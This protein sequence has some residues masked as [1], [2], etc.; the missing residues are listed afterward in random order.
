M[1]IVLVV[2]LMGW[3]MAF[4]FTLLNLSRVERLSVR[5]PRELPLVSIIIP[6]R[7]EEREIERTLSAL[8]SQTYPAIEIIVIDDRSTDS[9]PLILARAAAEDPRITVIS[10]V[11]EPP[12]G[13]LGKPWALHRGSLA[14][15]GELL[16]FVDAD[17]HY[18]PDAVAA[19]V[20]E[21]EERDAALLTLLPTVE[22][23]GFWEHVLMPNLAFFIYTV[24]PLWRTNRS[25]S[26]RLAVGGGTGNLVR[27]A[28]Y[29]AVG[30][31][32]TLKDAVVDDVAL[33][34]LMRKR[35]RR[36]RVVRAEDFVSVRMYHGLGEILGG[37]TKNAFAVFGRS[38]VVLT[39]VVLLSILFHILPWGYA[40]TG[41]AL[42]IAIVILA[43]VTR[44]ILFRDLRY[45][46]DNALLAHPL[47]IGMWCL[48]LIR[49]A[50]ITGVR[51]EL[52][53]RGRV[54]DARKT[55]FGAD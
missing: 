29:E 49:S 10:S 44:A 20:A 43:A 5:M 17:V 48:I 23:R 53:W 22:M 7:D 6:A 41:D 8:R 24:I 32:E 25:S 16:L 37:F 11:E 27:R 30:G 46:L 50:W 54:Y 33:A 42:A 13:W 47:M 4:V 38:Y 12:A 52:A 28:D 55:R 19:A 35:G 15:R 21:I 39:A 36:A 40:L 18:K 45:R 3:V 31:H 26:A 14:A 9:T 1:Q 51:R 2:V 34:R